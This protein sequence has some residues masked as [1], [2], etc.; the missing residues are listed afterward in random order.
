MRIIHD[1]GE[2]LTFRP[3]PARE[4]IEACYRFE[5]ALPKACLHPLTTP[6]GRTITGF[7][8]SDHIWHRGLWFTWKYVNGDNF[9]E[10]HPG[11]SGHQQ[12]A[13]E[14]RHTVDDDGTAHVLTE[15][16]WIAPDGSVVIDEQRDVGVRFEAERVVVDWCT[17]MVPRIDVRLDRT[18]FTTHGGYAGLGFRAARELHGV[19]F[20]TPEGEVETLTGESHPWAALDGHL[21]GGRDI[22][23]G[24]AFIDHPQNPRFPT[25]FY[26]KSVKHGFT[27]LN[28]T[29]LFHEPMDVAAG[30]PLDL[31]YRVL[32]ADGQ[33]TAEHLEAEKD[34]YWQTAPAG[35][36]ATEASARR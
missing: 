2:S 30:E 1:L 8:P 31:Q 20:L 29:F 28:P 25:P 3:H 32:V 34:A 24:L 12:L 9:W 7:Q 15:V 4:P 16:R 33:W 22:F 14:P 23:A 36:P 11:E 18:P 10:E 19:R 26:G 27:Y 21:D 13:R 5:P 35:P 6:T 17:R